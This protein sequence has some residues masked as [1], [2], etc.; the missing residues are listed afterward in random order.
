MVSL[1]ING[2]DSW[3]SSSLYF[4]GE[5]RFALPLKIDLF[6]GGE[7]NLGVHRNR[8]GTLEFHFSS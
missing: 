8:F 5:V 4:V 6:G 2:L 3:I 7:E 1:N